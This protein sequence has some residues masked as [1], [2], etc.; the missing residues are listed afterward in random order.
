MAGLIPGHQAMPPHPLAPHTQSRQ[1]TPLMLLKYNFWHLRVFRHSLFVWSVTP[2]SAAHPWFKTP[3]PQAIMQKMWP[4]QKCLYLLESVESDLILIYFLSAGTTTTVHHL[5]MMRV[6]MTADNDVIV[7]WWRNKKKVT[8]W[9][10]LPAATCHTNV[11]NAAR[12]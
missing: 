8:S 3:P 5:Q 1:V 4:L 2:P 6:K 12:L 7:S 11:L 10:S 9:S